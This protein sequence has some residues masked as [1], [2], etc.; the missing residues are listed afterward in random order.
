MFDRI[1]D[2]VDFLGSYPPWV[3]VV[4][5]GLVGT[6][7]FLFVLFRPLGPANPALAGDWT[8]LF[9]EYRAADKAEAISSETI[10]IKLR[11]NAVSADLSGATG[12]RRKRMAQ[13]QFQGDTLIL[14]Y[15]VNEPL[16][17]GGSAFVL[18]GDPG[19][20]LLRGFWLGYDPEQHKLMA[21]PY[22]LGRAQDTEQLKTDNLAWLQQS[23]YPSLSPT[24]QATA[25][26]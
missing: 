19:A 8:G 25:G 5:L 16:R 22:V 10:S 6:I 11:G 20:G 15:F 17:V 13:G 4:S 24:I 2:F 3:I 21:C 14:H 1:K 9:R 26:H 12:Q 23:C 18:K 7:V